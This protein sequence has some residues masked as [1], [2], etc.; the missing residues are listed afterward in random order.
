MAFWSWFI[1]AVG[2]FCNLWCIV[3]RSSRPAGLYVGV[4]VF[5]YTTIFFWSWLVFLFF[6]LF[7]TSVF[8]D[9]LID[10]L[11]V[12]VQ[13]FIRRC[14]QYKKE[15]RPDVVQ[16]ANED[17][18]KPAALKSKWV[19][20]FVVV[21]WTVEPPA[22]TICCPYVKVSML[23]FGQVAWTVVLPPKMACCPQVSVCARYWSVGSCLDEVLHVLKGVFARK[24]SC[25]LEGGFVK[26]RH[27]NSWKERF[28]NMTV[29]KKLQIFG[30]SPF[31]KGTKQQ[32]N[33]SKWKY[34]ACLVAVV[35]C[36][37][38]ISRIFS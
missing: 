30:V 11:C 33:S 8:T 29:K 22:K 21:V 13:N 26:S 35:V 28:F 6:V 27:I 37:N 17:Y 36:C 5:T 19:C 4:T 7:V 1:F 32:L 2:W 16:M 14:L 9:W 23:V 31:F 3:L 20:S 12:C 24:L 10:W 34:C 25:A 18:L 38:Q 15:L